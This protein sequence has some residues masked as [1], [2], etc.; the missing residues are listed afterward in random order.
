MTSMP[1]MNGMNFLAR[2]D[3]NRDGLSRQELQ[4]GQMA[5]YFQMMQ[6]MMTGNQAGFMSAMQDLQFA[7]MASQNFDILA[8]ASGGFR[9]DNPQ[10]ISPHD[11]MKTASND[12]NRGNISKQDLASQAQQNQMPPFMQMMMQMMQM[13]MQMIMQMMGMNQQ[14]QQPAYNNGMNQFN[15]GGLPQGFDLPYTNNNSG[16]SAMAGLYGGNNCYQ[17]SFNYGGDYGNQQAQNDGYSMKGALIGFLLGGPVGALVGSGIA[18]DMLQGLGGGMQDLADWV[19]GGF[20]KAGNW[21][22]DN[23][24]LVGGL[25]GAGTK[26]AGKLLTAPTKIGGAIIEGAGKV[27]SKIGKAISK[28]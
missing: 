20:Q 22:E 3:T 4:Q 26:F 28:L 1:T 5:S 15:N 7:S 11:L 18:G 14:Q 27:V 17:P 13:M 23:I 2:Y 8:Q 6:S 19:D 16:A 25:L 9:P 12:G 10:T 24:P 21:M